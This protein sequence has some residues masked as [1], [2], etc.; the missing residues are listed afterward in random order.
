MRRIEIVILLLL[1][2]SFC[3]A[4]KDLAKFAPKVNSLVSCLSDVNLTVN[5]KR[6]GDLYAINADVQKETVFIASNFI[7][8]KKTE[9]RLIEVELLTHKKKIHKISVKWNGF[10]P[11]YLKRIS[12]KNEKCHSEFRN[13]MKVVYSLKIDNKFDVSKLEHSFCGS[14]EEKSIFHVILSKSLKQDPKHHVFKISTT[15]ERLE[16]HY[17]FEKLPDCCKQE[18]EKEKEFE[19]DLKAINLSRNQEKKRPV[20]SAPTSEVPVSDIYIQKKETEISLENLK[21][22]ISELIEKYPT[23]ENDELC[24]LFY[25]IVSF[26]H[27]CINQKTIADLKCPKVEKKTFIRRLM[28]VYSADKIIDRPNCKEKTKDIELL[29]TDQLNIGKPV[30]TFEVI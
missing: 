29:L 23:K 9:I 2:K 1:S 7:K 4:D 16:I 27:E 28:V 24:P 3:M 25:E 21:D 22:K 11:E 30:N 12:C 14:L 5:T 17:S 13:F 10:D 19:K 20:E 6:S 26:K 8:D 15:T 18:E